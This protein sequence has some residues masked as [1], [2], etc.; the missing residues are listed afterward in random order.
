MNQS[1]LERH[2]ETLW[3]ISGGPDLEAEYRFHPQRKWRFD[4]AHP[5]TMTAIE[6]EGGVWSGGRHTTGKG[7]VGDCKK[8]NAAT[9]L[10]WRVFR[11]TRKMLDNP[12]HYEQIRDF[13]NDRQQSSRIMETD[14]ARRP[15]PESR[16]R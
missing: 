13:I 1:D 15:E 6:L 12:R 4:F 16:Q 5:E 9:L 7:F 3:Q 14:A 2:F 8:Y 10:G 11:L